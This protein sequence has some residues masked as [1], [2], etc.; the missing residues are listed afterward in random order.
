M[1]T[2]EENKT[3]WDGGYDWPMGGDEWSWHFGSASAQ[4]W[5]MLFPR[6]QGYLPARTI[7]EIAPGYGRWTRFLKDLCTEMVAVDLSAS[8]IEHC[9]QRFADCPHM[10]W[11]VNDGMSLAMVDDDSI[12]FVFSF[13]SLVHVDVSVMH[14]YLAQIAHKLTRHGVAFLHHSNVGAYPQ[15]SYDP[16]SV[17]WRDPSVSAPI[18]EAIADKVGL[19]CIAQETLVWHNDQVLNDCISVLTLP[20]S[21]WDRANIVVNNVRF[22]SH[23]RPLAMQRSKLYPPTADDAVFSV[24]PG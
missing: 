17:H 4:W 6:L 18:V 21:R 12:D 19:S 10:A 15:G 11:H 2:I 1:G 13:D 20:G 23:E 3:W 9:R 16:E 8:A 7:L 22:T 24:R 14:A 5:A